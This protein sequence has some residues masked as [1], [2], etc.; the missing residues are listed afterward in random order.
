MAFV[1][2]DFQVIGGQVGS[3]PK[4]CVYTTTEA[5]TAVRAADYFLDLIDT[6]EVNDVILVVS[7]SGG[8]PLL[9][10]TYVNSNTGTV[11]DVV[12]G[13]AIPTTDS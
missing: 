2:T 11:I 7:A 10:F 3:G 8:T 1:K 5:M 9:Y 13:L 4:F 12:D 6:L